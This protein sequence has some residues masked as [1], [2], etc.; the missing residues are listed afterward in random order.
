MDGLVPSAPL[1]GTLLSFSAA[2]HGTYSA[3]IMCDDT[4]RM[5]AI[6]WVLFEDVSGA[7]AARRLRCARSTVA[8]WIM[9]YK[10]T[11]E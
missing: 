4:S 8:A 2:R 9:A 3:L 11:R 10:D 7:E 1:K 6:S 5:V